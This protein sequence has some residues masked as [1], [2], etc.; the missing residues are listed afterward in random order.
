MLI[1]VLRKPNR[2]LS[3]CLQGL[4]PKSGFYPN[5]SDFIRS[6]IKKIAKC[7]NYFL[8]NDELEFFVQ[9]YTIKP[10]TLYMQWLIDH[11]SYAQVT[12][13]NNISPFIHKDLMLLFEYLK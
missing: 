11:M 9:K 3:C 13:I 1:V 5:N 8:T 12:K 4:E 7:H 2:C 10:K 6:L